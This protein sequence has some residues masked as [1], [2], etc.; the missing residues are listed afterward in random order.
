MWCAVIAAFQREHVTAKWLGFANVTRSFFFKCSCL[1]WSWRI[2]TIYEWLIQFLKCCVTFERYLLTCVELSTC[3]ERLYD[4]QFWFFSASRGDSVVSP[5]FAVHHFE[6]M[7]IFLEIWFDLTEFRTLLIFLFQNIVM[8]S[9]QG[10]C[11]LHYSSNWNILLG[12]C[13]SSGYCICEAV[14]VEMTT[15]AFGSKTLSWNQC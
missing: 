2:V 10:L 13:I 6:P 11:C 14:I 4:N 8:L 1:F 15:T 9:K 12:K 3:S 7:K 5:V